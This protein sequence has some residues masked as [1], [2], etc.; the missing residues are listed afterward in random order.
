MADNK[1]IKDGLGNLFTIRM[2][3]LTQV[4]DGS[5]QRSMVFSTLLPVDYTSGG[6]FQRTSRSNIMAAGAAAQSPIYSFWWPSATTLALVRRIRIS[7]WSDS[8]GFTAGLA[9]FNLLTL[10]QFLAEMTPGLVSDLTGNSAK[11]RTSMVT[12]QASIV[13]SDTA[14]LTGGTYTADPGATDI[15]VGSVGANAF[16]PFAAAPV[17]LF[18]KLQGEMPLLFAQYEGFMITATVPAT[19]TWRFAVTTEWDELPPTAGY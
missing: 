2:H 15:W 5:L 9:I 8:V 13:H 10:R 17:K 19:G 11:L 16:T 14:P 1:Q 6:A 7:A 12:S 3:D 18:E 4:Q